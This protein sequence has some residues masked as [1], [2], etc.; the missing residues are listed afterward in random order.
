MINFNI[1]KEITY[2]LNSKKFNLGTSTE[3]VRYLKGVHKS[4]GLFEKYFLS[5]LKNS[6]LVEL[7]EELSDIY[8]VVKPFSYSE[9]FLIKNDQFKAIVFGSINIGEMMEELGTIRIKTEGKLVKRKNYSKSGEFLGWV[10]NNVIFETH[11]VNGN[12]LGLNDEKLY[13]LKCWCTTTNKEHWLWID[14]QHKNSP[15]DAVASTFVINANLVPYIKELK[16]QGD[17]L[18]VELTED[19]TPSGEMISLTADQYFDKLTAES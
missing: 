16:R 11:E 14:G 7:R 4:K 5:K 2:E 10:E 13:A 8:D 15:L 1:T 3:I 6:A 12:K 18:L 19:I 17:V 9:A